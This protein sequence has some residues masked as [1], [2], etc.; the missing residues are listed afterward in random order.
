MSGGPGFAT[1]AHPSG[2]AARRPDR[3]GRRSRA[4]MA[5]RPAEHTAMTRR[6]PDGAEGAT[7]GVARRHRAGPLRFGPFELDFDRYELRLE[8]E[9]VPLEPRTFDLLALLARN[10]GR[11]VTRDE[12]FREVW[13]GRFVSDAALS[14]QIRSA[15]RALGDDGKRQ[16]VIATVHGRGFRLRSRPAAAEPAPELPEAPTGREDPVP[17][18]AVLPCSAPGDDGRGGLIA[19]GLTEDLINA[20]SR[21][22]WMR[23]IARSTAFALGRSGEPL[24]EIL[25]R[26]DADYA[27]TGSVRLAGDRV[28]ALF[29]LCETPGM[30]CIWSERFD[31]RLRDILDLQDELSG[32]V[33]GRIASQLGMTEQKRAARLRP[34]S[35]GAWELYQLGSAEFYR[36]TGEGNRRCQD[37]MRQALARAPDFAEPYA[38]LAYAMVLESVYF[39]GPTEGP[40]LDDA[41]RLAE[42][43]VE[44]DDQEANTFFALGRVQ[45]ARGEYG[46]AID[47][48]E[49]ALALNPWHALSHCGLGDSLVSDGCA[50]A[51]IPCFERALALSPHDPFRWA[52]MSYRSL[53]HMFLGDCEAAVHWARSATLVPNAHYWA[54]AKLISWLAHSGDLAAARANVPALMRARPGFSCDF[55]RSRLFFVPVPAHLE[56]FLDGLRAAG[57]P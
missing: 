14:S 51:A 4:T 25:R 1:L 17:C 32:L 28:R 54:R 19:E 44:L 45:L 16:A 57:V 40:H 3:S 55:A 27:V 26:L 35:P 37:L 6:A 15:R 50:E 24:D 23:V 22:R 47:A 8:G 41:L 20:L 56:L 48:L 33:A 52:F 11:T 34:G 5:S 39:D 36:F 49:T 38:R 18:I 30:R 43:G 13:P 12:I 53:A 9:P 46:L 21:N 10:R 42:R 7:G 2:N 29:Q 31:R